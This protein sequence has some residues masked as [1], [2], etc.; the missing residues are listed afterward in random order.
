MMAKN[1]TVT[2]K[3]D[4]WLLLV[5]HAAKNSRF[6]CAISGESANIIRLRDYDLPGRPQDRLA[7]TIVEAALATS[8]A[9]TF[10]DRVQINGRFFRDGGTGANNPIEQVWIEAGY[11]WN[12]DDEL[13]LNEIVGCVL[14]IGTGNPRMEPFSENTW[15]FL[16]E[17]L[18]NIAT[19]TEREAVNFEHVHR[20]LLRT[21]DKRYYR[22]NVQQGLQSVGLEEYKLKTQIETATEKYLTSSAQ[23]IEIRACAKILRAKNF[24]LHSLVGVED[25]S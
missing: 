1:E 7:M 2:R 8:A 21:A 25:W 9:A 20:V 18:V 13:Q 15:K 23:E 16:S 3:S 4:S 5:E 11:I 14:S 19:D 10:F 22:F 24:M 6:V 17:T 12:D